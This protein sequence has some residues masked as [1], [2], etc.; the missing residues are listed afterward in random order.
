[1]RAISDLVV[2]SFSESYADA[3]GE[4]DNN[5]YISS[6][7]LE[8]KNNDD[9]I[10]GISD[11]TKFC[12]ILDFECDNSF[13]DDY[14]EYINAKDYKAW[15][16]TQKGNTFNN[17]AWGYYVRADNLAEAK[18]EAIDTCNEYKYASETCSIVLEG[19]R[20]V[21]DTLLAKFDERNLN[22]YANSDN[23]TVC[24]RAT[25]SDGMNWEDINGKYGS[26]VQEA[27]SRNFDLKSC[28]AITKRFPKSQEKNLKSKKKL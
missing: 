9:T 24:L 28:R 6:S 14:K 13:E 26:A 12:T 21:N 3:N 11:F 19:N 17:P 18:S 7:S 27:W 16:V 25:T 4:S 8:N 15:A 22:I 20:I 23:L 5:T 10:I 1:M 2:T